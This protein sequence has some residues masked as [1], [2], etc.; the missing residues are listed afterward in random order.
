MAVNITLDTD[1]D[2]ELEKVNKLVV[3]LNDVKD[4]ANLIQFVS[5]KDFCK[6]T[7]WSEKTVQEI[8]NRP[9]FPSCDYGKEKKA[10][11]HAILK[12]FEVPRRR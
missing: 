2:K 11:V 1:L 12:Y 9:D 5:I 8:Y 7:G 10:E 6:L 4:Q 3:A